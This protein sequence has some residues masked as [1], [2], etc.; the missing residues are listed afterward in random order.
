M[1]HLQ[2]GRTVEDPP[3][4]DVGLSEDCDRQEGCIH[5]DDGPVPLAEGR[6]DV[7]DDVAVVAVGVSEGQVG[8]GEGRQL[9]LKNL[10]ERHDVNNASLYYIMTTDSERAMP[11]LG[12]HLNQCR[13]ITDISNSA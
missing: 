10:K 4:V 7:V 2:N 6:G 5:V 12:V 8:P 3:G 9:V 1:A 11:Y 13:N